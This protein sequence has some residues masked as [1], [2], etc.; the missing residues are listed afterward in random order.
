MITNE[1]FS[2]AKSQINEKIFS[3][4]FKRLHRWQW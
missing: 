3:A 4:I 2:I 1:I